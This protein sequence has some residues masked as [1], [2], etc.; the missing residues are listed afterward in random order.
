MISETIQNDAELSAYYS[1]YQEA[2]RRLNE[3]VKVRGFWPVQKRTEKGKTK[4]KGKS[5]AKGMFSGP[6]A[7]ARRIANSFC[8]I[9]LQKGHWKNE[10]PQQSN[11]SAG[12]PSNTASTSAPTSFVVVEEVPTELA[13]MAIAEE[14]DPWHTNDWGNRGKKINKR[15]K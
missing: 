8:R 6:G 9:C 14:Q 1:T 7:L 3:R 10:C 4:G 5:K 13:R 2:R 12:T 15:G 11:Q